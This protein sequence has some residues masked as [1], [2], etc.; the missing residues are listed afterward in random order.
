MWASLA[1]LFYFSLVSLS[2]ANHISD[3]HHSSGLCMNNFSSISP[4]AYPLAQPPTPNSLFL[5]VV[6]QGTGSVLLRGVVTV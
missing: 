2:K 4:T 5:A 3:L 1:A 6:R